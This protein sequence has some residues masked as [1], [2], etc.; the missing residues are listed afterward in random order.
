MKLIDLIQNACP[1]IKY[2]I[3]T[4]SYDLNE[5]NPLLFNMDHEEQLI[6]Y[7]FIAKIIDEKT[8]RNIDELIGNKQYNLDAIKKSP[9]LNYTY[10]TDNI[11]NEKYIKIW[12]SPRGGLKA[13]GLLSKL[14]EIM[15]NYLD[16]P[17]KAS[18]LKKYKNIP[19]FEKP[20]ISGS[21][22]YHF[23]SLSPLGIDNT[24]SFRYSPL[25]EE[26]TTHNMGFH[27]LY[28]NDIRSSASS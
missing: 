21:D 14:Y 12:L 23:E 5:Y 22:P 7:L 11:S 24:K 17:A 10:E 1:K 13:Q 9:Y 26:K 28:M 6:I 4:K 18:E 3:H 15:Q 27:Q 8:A 20:S 25:N 16:S 2:N 19:A